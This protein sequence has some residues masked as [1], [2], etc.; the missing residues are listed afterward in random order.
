MRNAHR[1]QIMKLTLS[2]PAMFLFSAKNSAGLFCSKRT[3]AAFTIC[4]P[5]GAERANT[6]LHASAPVLFRKRDARVIPDRYQK[7]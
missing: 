3:G 7:L 6:P 5:A 2:K 1:L 4:A